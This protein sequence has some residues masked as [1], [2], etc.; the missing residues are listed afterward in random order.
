MANDDSRILK[1][2]IRGIEQQH[3]VTETRGAQTG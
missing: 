1:I 2:L 3:V